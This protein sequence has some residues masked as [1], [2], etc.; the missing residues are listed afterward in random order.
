[1]RQLELSSLDVVSIDEL[2]AGHRVEIVLKGQPVAEVVPL[3][4]D[5]LAQQRTDRE[6]ARLQ[7]RE[8]LLALMEKGFDLGGFRINNRDELYDRG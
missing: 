3:D 1:M 5:A 2:A 8:R 6:A 7:A 4:L